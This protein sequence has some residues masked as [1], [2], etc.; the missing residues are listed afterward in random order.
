M[1][2]EFVFF[3]A[4]MAWAVVVG[5]LVCFVWGNPA[6]GITL[7]AIGLGLPLVHGLA[8]GYNARHRSN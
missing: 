2:V 3:W 8:R 6:A 5:L 7:V 4:I 1:R